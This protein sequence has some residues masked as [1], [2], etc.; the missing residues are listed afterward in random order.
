MEIKKKEKEGE[1]RSFGAATSTLGDK[2]PDGFKPSASTCKNDGE[3]NGKRRKEGSEPSIDALQVTLE[4]SSE[5]AGEIR[6][7]A[8]KIGEQVFASASDYLRVIRRIKELESVSEDELRLSGV[9]GELLSLRKERERVHSVLL[10]L[11][12]GVQS[13]FGVDV[14]IQYINTTEPAIVGREAVDKEI[15][16]VLALIEQGGPV[17]ADNDIVRI[18]KRGNKRPENHKADVFYID[19]K[20]DYR[21]LVHI[22]SQMEGRKGQISGAD[23]KLFAALRALINRCV[24]IRKKAEEEVRVSD[25]L[26]LED[27]KRKFLKDE[28]HPREISS[29]SPVP[30]LYH[31]FLP[32]RKINGEKRGRDGALIVEVEDRNKDKKETNPFFVIRILDGAGS[33]RF[34]GTEHIGKHINQWWLCYYREEKSLPNNVPDNLQ[35]FALNLCRKLDACIAYA[36]NVSRNR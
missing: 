23:K 35:E 15:M 25:T 12:E 17:F 1:T 13:Q 34:L 9:M 21:G 16:R 10:R 11:P 22:P 20:G 7:K 18:G 30:G 29:E 2:F 27:I 33:M 14:L 36:N 24:V 28:R 4:T 32:G 31:L 8:K 5:G 26:K 19:L 6:A 3:G